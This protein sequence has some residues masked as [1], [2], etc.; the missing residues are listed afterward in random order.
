MA[1][2]LSS[3]IAANTRPEVAPK[4]RRTPISRIRCRT[5]TSP[6]LS[7]PSAPRNSTSSPAPRTTQRRVFWNF[8]WSP[9][10]CRYTP[11]WAPS[12]SAD[13]WP[14]T[15]ATTASASASGTHSSSDGGP[16]ENC[17]GSRSPASHGPADVSIR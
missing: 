13:R 12:K 1:T 17:D 3:M 8:S 7:T 4:L 14:E 2:T 6:T 9:A 16:D 11:T 10:S 5:V 15:A